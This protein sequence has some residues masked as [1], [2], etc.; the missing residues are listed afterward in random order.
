[1]TGFHIDSSE[2]NTMHVVRVR[3]LWSSVTGRGLTNT[4]SVKSAAAPTRE[5]DVSFLANGFTN[6][7]RHL[8]QLVEPCLTIHIDLN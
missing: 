8:L 2:K 7:T 4:S 3:T 6:E 1:M 5:K